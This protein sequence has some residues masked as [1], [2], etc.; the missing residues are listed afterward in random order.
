MFKWTVKGVF[1]LRCLLFGITLQTVKVLIT[2][3]QFYKV[4]KEL[5][6]ISIHPKALTLF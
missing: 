6:Y 5:K 1:V 4:E 3:A 2:K